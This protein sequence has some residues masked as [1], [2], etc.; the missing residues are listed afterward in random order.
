L[1]IKR[2]TYRIL[3]YKKCV[4]QCYPTT[5]LPLLLLF[6]PLLVPLLLL[7]LLLPSGRLCLIVW[8]DWHVFWASHLPHCCLLN[9]CGSVGHPRKLTNVKPQLRQKKYSAYLPIASFPLRRRLE[10]LACFRT[11]HKTN[12][13]F[14]RATFEPTWSAK[15][16]STKNWMVAD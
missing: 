8:Q 15:S 6:L 11:T 1:S 16:R 13:T 4:V 3:Y 12:T 9:L 14:N 2:A 10:I 5:V 7:L